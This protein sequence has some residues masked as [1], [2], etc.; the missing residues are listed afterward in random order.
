MGNDHGAV[1]Q[2][3]IQLCNLVAQGDF[4]SVRGLVVYDLPF[5]GHADSTPIPSR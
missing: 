3:V 5:I 1:P 2:M 4:E